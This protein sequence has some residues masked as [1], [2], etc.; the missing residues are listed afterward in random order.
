MGCCASDIPRNN[1][2]LYIY[3]QKQNP[4]SSY[5]S[6]NAHRPPNFSGHSHQSSPQ[7][8]HMN[9]QQKPPGY[10]SGPPYQNNYPQRHQIPMNQPPPQYNPQIPPHNYHSPNQNPQYNF[11]PQIHQNYQNQFPPNYNQ[12]P[13][14]SNNQGNPYYSP[15]NDNSNIVPPEEISNTLVQMFSKNR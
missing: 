13:L 3:D 5:A 8:P 1:R 10:N 9:S 11:A 7:N 4:I 15:N 12:M 14:N 6:N 2:N